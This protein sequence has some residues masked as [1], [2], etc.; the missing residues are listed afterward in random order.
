MDISFKDYR[1]DDIH[2]TVLY[3][4]MMVAPVQKLILER[5]FKEEQIFSVFDPFHGSGTAL[6]ES[7]EIDRDINLFG[8]DINPLANLITTVKLNGVPRFFKSDMHELECK[9]KESSYFE[10]FSFYNIEKWFRPDIIESLSLLRDSISSIKHKTS[11]LYFWYTMCN[12]I[13]KYSNTRTSTY[14]LHIKKTNEISKT[15]NNVISNFISSAKNNISKFNKAKACYKLYKKDI[16]KKSSSFRDNKFDITITSPPYGDNGTTVTYGQFSSL[17]LQW[18]PNQDLKIDGW[19]RDNYS[20]IDSKS[21]GGIR[22]DKNILLGNYE[23]YLITD[24]LEKIRPH[25]RQKVINFFADYF[26]SLKEMCRYTKKYIIL[27]LG[28]RT[29]DG[30]NIDLTDISSQYLEQHGFTQLTIQRRHIVNKR[31]PKLTSK[32]DNKAVSSMNEEFI[33]V[34]K[35]IH[36]IFPIK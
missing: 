21:L 2:G 12:I 34:H 30:V 6:F 19:E 33:I 20:I 1:K 15:T 11:R 17:A 32:V 4:A 26:F 16:L 25:K 36:A 31:I 28:N 3:P 13:R 10:Y 14:K 9:L 23:K 7:Y 24:Y 29:V 5:I 22:R 27:T 8:C 35:R 18:I